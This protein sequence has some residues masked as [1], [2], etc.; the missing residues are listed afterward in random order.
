MEGA[1]ANDFAGALRDAARHFV[2]G[3]FGE[4]QHQNLFGSGGSCVQQPCDIADDGSG[5]AGSRTC[6]HQRIV[7]SSGDGADLL[8]VQIMLFDFADDIP[9]P[10]NLFGGKQRLRHK[11]LSRL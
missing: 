6:K 7:T 5:F 4:R 2:G 10:C 1:C 8:V 11:L 3:S 9:R